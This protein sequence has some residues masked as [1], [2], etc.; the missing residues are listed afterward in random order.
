MV[1]LSAVLAPV[2]VRF[3]APPR[4]AL[5]PA[6]LSLDEMPQLDLA[7]IV[8][9]RGSSIVPGEVKARS[10]WR[11]L[12]PLWLS[13][14]VILLG[15]LVHLSRVSRDLIRVR[16]LLRRTVAWRS[17][18]N[19]RVAVSDEC[20]VPFSVAFLKEAYVVVPTHMLASAS[21]VR[22][23]IVHELQHHRQGDCR[24]AYLLELFRAV[25]FWNPCVH[26]WRS[27]LGDLQEFAC[28]EVLVGRRPFEPHDYGR[29]L[30]AVA[31]AASPPIGPSRPGFACVVGM[32]REGGT[33]ASLLRRRVEMLAHY[34]SATPRRTL[35]AVL[36]SA[37]AITTLV[38][39][40]YAAQ[41]TLAPLDA[42]SLDLSRVEARLQRIA[43]ADVK[44]ALAQ[45]K[46]KSV[47]VVV[48]QAQTGMVVAFAEA[49]AEKAEV[50]W[51]K[52]AF[53][54]GSTTKPFIAAAALESGVVSEH[55]VL[56]C[57][58]PYE[59][60]GKLFNNHDGNRDVKKV[61]MT[62]AIAQSVNVC[63]IK[64]AQATG[65]ER[66][67][68]ILQQFGL[69][70]T[71]RMSGGKELSAD[72][73]EAVLGVTLPE[74]LASMIRAYGVLANHGRT[75][76]PHGEQ[77]VSRKTADAIVRMLVAAVDQGTGSRA[78]L[79]G[80]SVAGKT[81]TFASRRESTAE[82]NGSQVAMF[83]GFAPAEA[84]RLVAFVIIEGGVQGE[85]PA[86]GGAAAAPIFGEVMGKSLAALDQAASGSSAEK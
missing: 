62:E 1:L 76:A 17:V 24:T 32:A 49:H 8:R 69:W 23:A 51:A 44:D 84:P 57:P 46:A 70:E 14:A 80:V 19:V 75:R 6:V 66:V 20:Q 3:A 77:V 40:A 64:M 82:A 21:H 7:R 31:Q 25:F 81:G 53:R 65:K 52:R 63:T 60:G 13:W 35:A 22:M 78:K 41:G 9:A 5:L 27:S 54:P 15:G 48:A 43:E 50:S 16:R 61:S 59:I 56:D 26:L 67:R 86:T 28:D 85:A 39:L 55:Q 29:C 38:G 74:N 12:D 68:E 4:R 18:G 11:D 34:R 42:P 10:A 33:P 47:A 2:L 30:L 71:E 83:G 79:S 58:S 37:F 45:F 36:A 73:A 72:D